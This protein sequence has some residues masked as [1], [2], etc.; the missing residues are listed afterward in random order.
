[1]RYISV[2]PKSV[3]ISPVALTFEYP[4][5]DSEFFQLGYRRIFADFQYPAYIANAGAVQGE[6]RYLLFYAL[7]TSIIAIIQLKNFVAPVAPPAPTAV[8]TV[9]VLH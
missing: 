2:T 5:L 1:L 3:N 9:T 4:G 6:S 7:F 8:F